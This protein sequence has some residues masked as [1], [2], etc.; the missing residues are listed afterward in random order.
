MIVTIIFCY[1]CYLRMSS[2][3]GSSDNGFLHGVFSTEI[4]VI[5]WLKKS[6]HIFVTFCHFFF[7]IPAKW[8]LFVIAFFCTSTKELKRIFVSKI[9]SYYLFNGTFIFMYVC[10]VHFF[11]LETQ[12]K[13]TNIYLCT[14]VKNSYGTYVFLRT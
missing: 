9:I 8:N 5:S 1:V 13:C 11:K 14:Y 7:Q 2:D 4:S 12:K 6:R 3:N 10:S